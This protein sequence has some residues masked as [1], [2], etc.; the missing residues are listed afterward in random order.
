MLL[1]LTFPDFLV[2]YATSLSASGA[3]VAQTAR[4]LTNSINLWL[5]WSFD[6]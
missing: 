2:G 4:V 1:S 5:F 6:Q 3:K